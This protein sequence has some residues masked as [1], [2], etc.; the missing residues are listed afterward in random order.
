MCGGVIRMKHRRYVES[1]KEL[2]SILSICLAKQRATK[3][4]RT[5]DFYKEAVIE[6]S[7]RRLN[8]EIT[9]R[10]MRKAKRRRS[11]PY[12]W[13]NTANNGWKTTGAASF[14]DDEDLLGIDNFFRELK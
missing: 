11:E 8:D 5:P 13:K 7:I 6:K 4:K 9:E 10:C 3:R 1:D 12:E 14:Q 2:W